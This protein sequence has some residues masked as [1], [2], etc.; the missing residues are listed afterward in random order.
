MASR[1]RHRLFMASIPATLLLLA[2][3]G[4]GAEEPAVPTTAAVEPQPAPAAPAPATEPAAQT[5]TPAAPEPV[6][7]Q[8]EAPVVETPMAPAPAA[9]AAPAP[10]PAAPPATPPALDAAPAP[11]PEGVYAGTAEAVEGDVIRIGSTRFLLYGIDTVE[12]PQVCEIDRQTWECWPAVVRQLETFLGEGP[13]T[14]T[15]VRPTDPF[16]RVLSLC[17]QNGVSLNERMVR[18]GFA[19]AVADE[20]PEYVAIEAEARAERIGLWQGTFQPPEE[21]RSERGIS[22]RRP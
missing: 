15:A 12:P 5:P 13:V 20:M 9:P 1:L 8:P 16:G 10:A 21:W 14:C 4:D 17:E 7:R 6:A 19:L 3:C 11:L 2:A 18:T 22:I